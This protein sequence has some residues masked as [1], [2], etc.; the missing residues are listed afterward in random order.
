MSNNYS[1]TIN[2]KRGDM[3]GD[4][5]NT[6][7]A[8]FLFQGCTENLQTFYRPKKQNQVLQFIR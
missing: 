2:K 6:D 5:K 3:K 7:C 4:I 8:L 1:G